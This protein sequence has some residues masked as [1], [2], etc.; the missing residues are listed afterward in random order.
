MDGLSDP[1]L[2]DRAAGDGRVLVSHDLHTI[3]LMSSQAYFN[4]RLQSGAAFLEANYDRR[5]GEARCLFCPISGVD[6]AVTD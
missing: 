1:D 3:S 4:G 2:R 6:T 5:I